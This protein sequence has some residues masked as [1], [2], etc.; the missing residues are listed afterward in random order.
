MMAQIKKYRLWIAYSGIWILNFFL[1]WLVEIIMYYTMQSV[2]RM[3]Q[4]DNFLKTIYH[5]SSHPI[6]DLFVAFFAFVALFIFVSVR[7]VCSTLR[8]HQDFVVY[9]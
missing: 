3:N 4:A 1:F 8:H 9:V 2:I 6:Q 7:N 5:L